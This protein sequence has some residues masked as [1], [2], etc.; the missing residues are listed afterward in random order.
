MTL[1]TLQD[2][3]FLLIDGRSVL[4]TVTNISER[5]DA[6]LE[7]TTAGQDAADEWQPVG[8]TEWELSQ[9]GFYD[10]DAGAANEAYNLTGEET[11]RGNTG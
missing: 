9:E 10:P 7:E 6:V 8:L 1:R 5:H 4:G 2:V 3:P 11:N